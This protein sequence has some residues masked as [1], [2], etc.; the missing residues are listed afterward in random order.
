MMKKNN[1]IKL[2]AICVLIL[3]II[4]IAII[5]NGQD[6]DC[7]RCALKFEDNNMTLKINMTTIYEEY[8]DDSCPIEK[9]NGDVRYDLLKMEILS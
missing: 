5:I 8:L 7:T 2:Q 6:L 3:I 4:N 1:I 9:K